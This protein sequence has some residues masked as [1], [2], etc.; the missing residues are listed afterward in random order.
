MISNLRH[1]V[2]CDWQGPIV[3]LSP[4]DATAHA[5]DDDG[6]AIC[7]SSF[8]SLNLV[9]PKITNES[10]D[11]T[12]QGRMGA[13]P[14]SRLDRKIITNKSW[15]QTADINFVS[16][17]TTANCNLKS[18]FVPVTKDRVGLRNPKEA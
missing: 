2:L 14:S 3:A 1:E 7:D 11:A 8:D 15:Y 13:T 9:K 16:L 17:C 4:R 18:G 5:H 6:P 12:D 10:G